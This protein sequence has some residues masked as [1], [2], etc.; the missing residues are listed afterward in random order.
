M[1]A[2]TSRG[3]LYIEF[4]HVAPIVAQHKMGQKDY[5]PGTFINEG[6]A[7]TYCTI[8]EG[9]RNGTIVA[10]G[11]SIIHPLDVNR[12]NREKGRVISLGNTLN[13]LF[14]GVSQKQDRT[15]LW[16]A[17]HSRGASSEV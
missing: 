11:R 16:E 4:R 7:G 15:V 9:D 14:P 10:Q 12:F 5:E 1:K 2:K 17:Y 3:E 13:T 6:D 8:K